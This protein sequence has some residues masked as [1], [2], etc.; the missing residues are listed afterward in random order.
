M[1]ISPCPFSVAELMFFASNSVYV[2]CKLGVRQTIANGHEPSHTILHMIVS[3]MIF[4]VILQSM[5]HA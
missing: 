3:P 4:I 5:L 2:L 1:R